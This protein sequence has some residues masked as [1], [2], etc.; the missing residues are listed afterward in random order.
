MGTEQ[1]LI[2]LITLQ[3]HVDEYSRP[4]KIYFV[5]RQYL[6]RNNIFELLVHKMIV[7]KILSFLFALCGEYQERL[8]IKDLTDHFHFDHHF[9]LLSPNADFKQYI[10][11]NEDTPRTV[12]ITG[13]VVSNGSE[14][15][16][17]NE[18]DS[19][20]AFM[21]VVPD[22]SEFEQNFHLLNGIKKIQRLQ[23]NLDQKIGLFFSQQTSS[24][25]YL[26][27]FFEWCKDNLVVN[28]FAVT[29]IN[30]EADQ[31]VCP[32]GSLNI[33]T[34][35]PFGAF[36]VL[37][38]TGSKTFD[39]FFPSKKFNFEQH[40]LRLKEPLQ[41]DAEEKQWRIIFRVMNA[42]YIAS[43]ERYLCEQ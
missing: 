25:D 29:Y 24:E 18:I 5:S 10:N 6:E 30:W 27:K 31:S 16:D 33:F 13:S 41:D 7:E 43:N 15:G 38:V 34:F 35:K 12:Y 28:I 23:V 11:T 42:S 22:S 37:N 8:L 3:S 4:E 19:K 9:F 32:K 39:D 36:N 14:V 20:N 2:L 17:L 1:L 21:V 26:R 40:E